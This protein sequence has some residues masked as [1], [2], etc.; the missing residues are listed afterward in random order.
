MPLLNK[1]ET[2]DKTMVCFTTKQRFILGGIMLHSINN[3]NDINEFLDKTNSLHDGYVI[4]VKYINNGISKIDDGH[5][6]EPSKTKLG[7]QILVTSICDA[8]VEIEFENLLE[9]QIRDNQS[10]IFGVSVFF[11]ENNLIVWTDDIYISAEEMKKGSYVIAES[12]KWRMIQ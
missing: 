8:V 11:N 5:H 2:G 6:F 9:W 3:T 10:D 12:M 7:L 4:G 1:C